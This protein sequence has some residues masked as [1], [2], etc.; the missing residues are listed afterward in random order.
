MPARSHARGKRYRPPPALVFGTSEHLLAF[1]FG[2][3]LVPVAPGTFGTLLG[4]PLWWLL[5]WLP[6][7]IY[8]FVVA[9]LF[10]LGCWVTGRSAR[11][12][13]SHDDPGIVFDEVVGF[14]IAA[15]P[16]LYSLGWAQGNHWWWLLAAFVL[17]RG[18]DIVKPIPIRWLDQLVGGGLGIMLDDAVAGLFAAVPL[19]LAAW[20][21]G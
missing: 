20:F 10:G 5:C 19:G 3:G 4:V 16:L 13:G 2:L 8:G 18:F 12:L 14:L 11:L 7:Q 15:S 21:L 9:A 1:G 6:P 17:F